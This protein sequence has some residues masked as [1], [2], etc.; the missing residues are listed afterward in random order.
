MNT[1]SLIPITLKAYVT[2]AALEEIKRQLG[3]HSKMDVQGITTSKQIR[4]VWLE[5]K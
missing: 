4:I 5:E 3:Y 2:P 1:E